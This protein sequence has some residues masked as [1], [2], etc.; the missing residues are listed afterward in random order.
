MNMII[1]IYC[2]NNTTLQI[3]YCIFYSIKKKFYRQ[4]D[5]DESVDEIERYTSGI[6]WIPAF[7]G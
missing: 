1:M 4:V 2:F 5:N 6:N 7:V 3:L